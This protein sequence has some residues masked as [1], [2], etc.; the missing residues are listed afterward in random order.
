MV[1]SHRNLD[2]LVAEKKF[3]ED[4][5]FRVNI[6]KLTLPK[7]A[8]RKED[9]PLLA[10]YFVERLARHKEQ[11]HPGTHPRSDGGFDLV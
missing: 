11:K 5:Y 10:N 3:R 8:E 9:I 4:L 1:A 2:H 7:L 6:M